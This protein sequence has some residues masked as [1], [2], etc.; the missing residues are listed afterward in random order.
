MPRMAEKAINN[1]R[2]LLVKAGEFNLNIDEAAV[3]PENVI[4]R[5]KSVVFTEGNNEAEVIRNVKAKELNRNYD[6]AAGAA[7]KVLLKEKSVV[8]TEENNGVEVTQNSI[9][10]TN[11]VRAEP[12]GDSKMGG[13]EVNSVFADNNV[14]N[15]S[16]RVLTTW[17]I[18]VLSGDLNFCPTRNGVDKGALMRDF[19][20]FSRRMKCKAHFAGNARGAVAQMVD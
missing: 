12:E 10:Q 7:E 13:N 15:L 9:I 19:S 14:L 18:K 6:E 5:G 1:L 3:A 11:F 16:E 17:E 8:L 2:S 20:E 4:L